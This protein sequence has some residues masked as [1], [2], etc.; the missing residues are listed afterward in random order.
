MK[1]VLGWL[2]G[3]GGIGRLS[4]R[5]REQA[6]SHNLGSGH[7]DR[8]LE[9]CQD[10]IAGKPAPT[11]STARIRA[12]IGRL[13]GRLREQARS[14]NLGSG[15]SDRKPGS[16][17]TPSLASQLPQFRPRAFRQRSVGCQAAFASKLAPTI[18]ARGI[19]I[20]KREPAGRHR[21]QAS[22]HHFGRAHSDRDRSAVRPPSRAGSLPQFGLGAFR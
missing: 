2:M 8:K 4:G 18:W 3:L 21:W 22:S 1:I 12:E 19:Q 13:S 17:R 9:A 6:R 5:L 10:A 7:S 14:H 16:V 20:E 11:I 15:H